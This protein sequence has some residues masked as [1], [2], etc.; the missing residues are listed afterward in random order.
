M[1]SPDGKTVALGATNAELG[2]WDVATG[3]KKLTELIGHGREV[4][5]TAYSPDGNIIATMTANGEVR[6]WDAA[7]GKQ[8]L[9]FKATTGGCLN[10]DPTGQQL[11]TAGQGS[12]KVEFCD[13]ATGKQLRMS[14]REKKIR[15]FAFTPDGTLL[16]AV[17]STSNYMWSSRPV[18]DNIHSLGR[19]HR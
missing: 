2:Q 9:Q 17:G 6:L 15:Q 5:A 10:F 8:R 13:P 11:V 7:T 18:T 3:Q 4:C 19:G 16:V 14:I 12:G 1:L